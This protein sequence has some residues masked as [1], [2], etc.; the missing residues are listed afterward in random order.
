M[1]EVK[2]VSAKARTIELTAVFLYWCWMEKLSHFFPE[3]IGV[4]TSPDVFPLNIYSNVVER[5]D[6]LYLTRG[7]LRSL[8]KATMYAAHHY[9]SKN[10]VDT[11]NNI[12][13]QLAH[14]LARKIVKMGIKFSAREHS[15]EKFGFDDNV[16]LTEVEGDEINTLVIEQ[17]NNTSPETMYMERKLDTRINLISQLITSTGGWITSQDITDILSQPEA[18]TR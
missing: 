17:L 11:V 18:H 2:P 5:K 12:F 15:L 1:S 7:N 16:H 13:L 6:D 4:S 3:R 10:D 14:K 9:K 8:L